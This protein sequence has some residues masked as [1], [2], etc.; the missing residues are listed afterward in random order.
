V[1]PE[2]IDM[3]RVERVAAWLQQLPPPAN[4]V[5]NPASAADIA[6]GKKI[7]ARA[8]ESCHGSP[9]NQW[10]G[11]YVGKV[12]PLARIGTDASR[13]LSYTYIFLSS[14]WTIGSDHDWRFNHFRKTDGYANMPLDGLW[15]RAP[16]LH[17]GSVPTLRD[18]LARPPEGTPESLAAKAQELRQG[19]ENAISA[20]IREARAH[21]ERPLLFYRGDEVIDAA[22]VGFLAERGHEGPRKHYLYDTT[23]EGCHATGHS[24]GTELSPEQKEWL[25]A[26]LRTL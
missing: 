12:E 11:K 20:S 1:T 16:Y 13:L 7:Y 14:Q 5:A 26:F 10:Q 9:E 22:N 15:A 8:C 17:N 18:L 3:P 19:G 4:P 24:Y 6:E 2:S 21:G 23:R 25:L